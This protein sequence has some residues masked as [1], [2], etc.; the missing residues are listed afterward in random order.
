MHAA[1]R[2]VIEYCHCLLVILITIVR[3]INVSYLLVHSCRA[4]H[5]RLHATPQK[6]I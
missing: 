4:I 6:E 5:F 3:S 1:S 2:S